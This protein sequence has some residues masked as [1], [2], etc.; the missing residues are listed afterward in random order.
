MG[1]E[2]KM[3]KSVRQSFGSHR[4]EMRL[5][6]ADAL[7]VQRKPR[8]IVTAPKILLYNLEFINP[9]VDWLIIKISIIV[10][11]IPNP[12][13][14]NVDLHFAHVQIQSSQVLFTF[15]KIAANTHGIRVNYRSCAP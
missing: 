9:I 5:R 6:S 13:R 15:Y 11:E 4:F 14:A 3:I 1:S 8:T 2:A 10:F 7:P 12:K